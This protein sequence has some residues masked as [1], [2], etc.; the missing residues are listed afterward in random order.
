MALY[1][2]Q[3]VTSSTDTAFDTIQHPGNSTT[4]AGIYRC[5]A[6][7]HEIAIAEGHTLP[8][9]THPQHPRGVPIQWKLH[10]F[11]QHNRP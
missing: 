8:P 3:P 11:A 9:E 6:C 5:A 4:Y 2:H 7:G 1:K 10:V